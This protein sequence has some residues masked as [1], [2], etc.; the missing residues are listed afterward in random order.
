MANIAPSLVLGTG[1]SHCWRVQRIGWLVADVRLG[2]YGASETF[3]RNQDSMAS[4]TGGSSKINPLEPSDVGDVEGCWLGI[5]DRI[6]PNTEDFQNQEND[7]IC[8]WW[9]EPLSSPILK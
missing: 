7:A 6:S 4:G 2:H 3:V 9:F 5:R 8:K 1:L